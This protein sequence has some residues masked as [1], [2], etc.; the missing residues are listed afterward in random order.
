M[1]S[2][3]GFW[4]NRH[5]HVQKFPLPNDQVYTTKVTLVISSKITEVTEAARQ[6]PKE[7]LDQKF[8]RKLG[9]IPAIG[10]RNRIPEALWQL[11]YSH[12][13]VPGSGGDCLKK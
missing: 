4:E 9:V 5:L 3:P 13:P 6:E 11:G 10:D 8:L 12:H 7:Q 2:I 1:A